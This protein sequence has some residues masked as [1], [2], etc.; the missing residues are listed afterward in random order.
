MMLMLF[1][2]VVK[3]NYYSDLVSEN[4]ILS[5]QIRLAQIFVVEI[6]NVIVMTKLDYASQLVNTDLTTCFSCPEIHRHLEYIHN[7]YGVEKEYIFFQKV[8]LILP[9]IILCNYSE[10]IC[11]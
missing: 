5:T 6:S 4:L 1:F 3:G 10:L 9:I 11:V 2:Y 7:D 8:N